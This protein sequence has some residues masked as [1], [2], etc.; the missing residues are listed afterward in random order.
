MH[1]A[2]GLG[3]DRLVARAAAAP[4]R[5]AAA[6][7]EADAHAVLAEH[8][9]QPDLGFVKLPAR[10]DEAA[11]L[12]GVGIGEHHLLLAAAQI[13]ELAVLGNRQQP[14]HHADAGAQ[15]VDRLEQRNQRQRRGS[16]GGVDEAGLLHQQRELEHVRHAVAVRND[17]GAN[18]GGTVFGADR[19]RGAE[20]RQFARRLL[21]VS[22]E[23][24]DERARRNELLTQEVDALVLAERAIVEAGRDG[25]E[26]LGHRA[27]VHLG[28]LAQ[29]DR[30]QM[31]SEYVDGPPKRPQ[32]SARDDADARLLQGLRDRREVG[33][34][35]VH[36]GVGGQVDDRLAKRD[37]VVEVAR[38][39]GEARIHAGDGAAIGLLAAG[40]GGIAGGF[41]QRRELAAGGGEIGGERQFAAERVQFIEVI[42]ERPGALQPHR[43]HQHV[44]GDEGIAVAVA[45]DP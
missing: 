23:R 3:E 25:G 28:V 44:G 1:R 31:E 6:V 8:F 33:A 11:V 10:G 40:G 43:I 39:F 22:V 24:R 34:E 16:G 12:V 19:P 14:V 42:T 17:R 32:A 21:P 15:V 27:F 4:D 38:R 35:V 37:D 30:R 20:E 45:A 2:A 41:G 29:V 5:A 36:R 7:E 9:D 13:D 26:K 18:G